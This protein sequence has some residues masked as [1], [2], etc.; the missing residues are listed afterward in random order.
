MKKIIPK[1]GYLL[2]KKIERTTEKSNIVLLDNEETPIQEKIYE[3]QYISE[4]LKGYSIGDKV[5]ISGSSSI[6][7]EGK[8]YDAVK[9]GHIICVIK[10]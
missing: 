5:K 10:E 4:E 8:E 3:I 2:L 9:E 7:I 1:N 6:I